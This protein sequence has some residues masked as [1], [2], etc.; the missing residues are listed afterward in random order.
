MKHVLI[1]D[2]NPAPLRGRL[3]SL[4]DGYQGRVQV[5]DAGS[6]CQVFRKMLFQNKENTKRGYNSY[7]L[8]IVCFTSAIEDMEKV[9]FIDYVKRYKPEQPVLIFLHHPKEWLLRQQVINKSNRFG[10]ITDD[11]NI[12]EVLLKFLDNGSLN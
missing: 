6:I 5:E 10:K 9:H 11:Q 2:T 1:L 7:D 3:T 4:F 12:L 8:F